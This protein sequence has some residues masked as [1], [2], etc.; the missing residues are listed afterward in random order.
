MALVLEISSSAKLERAEIHLETGKVLAYTR[1]GSP[2]VACEA[3]PE[4][5]AAL[6]AALASASGV[7]KVRDDD[8]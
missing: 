1:D 3:T 6:K 2:P 5:L 4:L 7:T 8:D